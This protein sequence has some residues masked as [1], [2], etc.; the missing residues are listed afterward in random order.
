ML[1]RYTGRQDIPIACPATHR[2]RPELDPIIGFFVNTLALRFDI[3]GN[4]SFR[5][6]L[7]R[8]RANVT[9][10]A[11]NMNIIASKGP[12]RSGRICTND[13]QSR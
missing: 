5:E 12:D 10:A 9:D 6:L 1:A 7:Q 3:S 4:P 11:R 13:P 2:T 8:A